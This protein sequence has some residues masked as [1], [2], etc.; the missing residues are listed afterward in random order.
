MAPS[1]SELAIVERITS[2]NAG[3]I[4]AALKSQ[5]FSDLIAKLGTAALFESAAKDMLDA[6]NSRIRMLD[7]AWLL[8]EIPS[9]SLIGFTRLSLFRDTVYAAEPYDQALC[10]LVAE[11]LGTGIEAEGD[12]DPIARDMSAIQAGLTPELI[13]FQPSTYHQV[14]DVAGFSVIRAP[15]P[16]A[17]ESPEAD[18]TFDPEHGMLMTQVEQRL[19]T[20]VETGL[21]DVSGPQWIKQRVPKSIRERW[22]QRRHEERRAERPVFSLIQYSDFMDL[23]DVI[24]RSDNW[25]DV[26]EPIFRHANDF[27]E[28]MRRLHPI[29]KAIGHSRPIG[30]ADILTLRSE[31][32]RILRALGVAF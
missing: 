19:R 16:Q 11:E 13:A 20:C 22:E 14:I 28:S 7:T 27:R 30:R 21:R 15:V 26:F 6:V 25:R 10:E 17:V 24:N 3:V 31:S 8:P 12:D 1:L 29:R 32:V 23:C 4:D 5:A 9:A 2:Q 18:T